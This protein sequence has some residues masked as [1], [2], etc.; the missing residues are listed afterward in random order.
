MRK[1]L[2]VSIALA[3]GVGLWFANSRDPANDAAPTR[4]TSNAPVEPI[5]NVPS[6][7]V[8]LSNPLPEIHVTSQV[9]A[10][11]PIVVNEP[12]IRGRVIDEFDMPVGDAAVTVYDVDSG[13]HT[14]FSDNAGAFAIGDLVVDRE[15]RVSAVKTHYNEVVKENVS[16]ATDEVVLV[17]TYTSTATGRVVEQSGRPVTHFDLV[18]LNVVVDDDALWKE[19]VRSTATSWQP[20]EHPDG[21]Y[22]IADIGSSAPFTLGARA[23]GFEPAMIV[24]PAAPPGEQ[25]TLPDIVLKPEARVDGLVLSPKREPVAGANVHL[26]PDT[27]GPTIGRTDGSG[28]FLLSGLGE[29]SLEL[30]ADHDAY[31]PA[32]VQAFPSRGSAKSVEIILGQGGALVG[33]ITRSNQA[34][35]GQTVLVVLLDKPQDRKQAITDQNGRYRIDGIGA[36]TFDVLAKYAVAGDSPLRI[37]SKVDIAAGV[38]TTLNFNF[39]D[40]LG[41]IEGTI[42]TNGNPVDLAEIKGTVDTP[43]GQTSFTTTARDDGFYRVESIIPGSA[44][45]TV[46]ARSNDADLRR[47]AATEVHGGEVTRLDIDFDEGAILSGRVTNIA[48]D[49]VGQVFAVVG[50]EPVD[51]S[52]VEAILRLESTK[53]GE[54][55]IDEHGQFV[56]SGLESSEYTLIALVFQKDPDTGDDA[57]NTIRV[58]TATTLLP[59]SGEVTVTLTLPP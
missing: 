14:A 51:V 45:V 18:Y 42:T 13:A 49:E 16:G 20:F 29:A 36:G 30:T 33:R 55:D 12:A 48:A 58:A 6:T 57:I 46:F 35:P 50:Y 3:A 19:V 59:Q 32:T 44:W 21:R 11:A 26:G 17:L 1:G 40:R 27:E 10:P 9:N 2:A 34:A 39:P 53:A 37:Q 15:Y 7:P 31:V 24:A 4:P 28:R 41:T 56:I 22:E 43:Q 52:T 38:D 23:T 47:T 54:S 8:D 25:A 5:S